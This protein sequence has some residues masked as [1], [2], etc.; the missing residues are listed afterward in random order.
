M[1]LTKAVI[2]TCYRKSTEEDV[3]KPSDSGGPVIGTETL[4][5]SYAHV[6]PK[7]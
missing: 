3:E 1:V 4:Q 6:D 2:Y 7:S 5:H